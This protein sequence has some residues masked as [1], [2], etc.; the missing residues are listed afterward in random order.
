[1]T[2]SL[3]PTPKILQLVKDFKK[4]SN[5]EN[6]LV[7]GFKAEFNK[8]RDE[9]QR[10]V[11]KYLSSGI[12]DVMVANLIGSKETGFQVENSQVHVF[13]SKGY[14]FLEGAKTNIAHLLF[15]EVLLPKLLK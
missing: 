1:M 8:T 9:L 10:I 7:V 6:L 13:T 2:I 5:Q 12:A 3:K 4:K 15:S 14:S 11:S